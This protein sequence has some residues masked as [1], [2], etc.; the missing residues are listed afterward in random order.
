MV[1]FSFCFV[2]AFLSLGFSFPL[3]GQ[4]SQGEEG[5]RA[6][7]IKKASSYV[8]IKERTGKN[9]GKQILPFQKCVNIPSGS[10]WC[11]GFVCKVFEDIGLSSGMDGRAL[12]CCPDELLIYQKGKGYKKDPE[13]LDLFYF[14]SHTGFIEFWPPDSDSF[15]AIDGNA[16]NSVKKSLYKKSRVSRIA[17][18]VSPQLAE[19]NESEKPQKTKPTKTKKTT[20]KEPQGNPK[21]TP[22]EP[23]KESSNLSLLLAVALL[24]LYRNKNKSK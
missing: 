6:R 18:R 4:G 9:D 22:K 21:G 17:D 2:F 14:P 13:P 20:P 11:A 10:P 15:F 5:L 8:G 1:R 16:S 19:L 3:L 23:Q 7:G 24:L 12:S